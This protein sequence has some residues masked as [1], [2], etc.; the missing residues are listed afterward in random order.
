MDSKKPKDSGGGSVFG[1]IVKQTYDQIIVP[2]TKEIVNNAATD[3]IYMIG[4]YLSNVIGKRIFGPDS[5]VN[6]SKRSNNQTNYNQRYRTG[7]QRSSISTTQSVP[8]QQDIGMR[9]AADLQYVVAQSREQADRWKDEMINA[10]RKYGK[11]AVSDLY[12][13]TAENPDNTIKSV[14]TDF[15]Y[16]WTREDEIHWVH[17]RDGYYFDLPRPHKIR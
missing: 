5:T 8:Q 16:G 4:D 13:K 6:T 10:I 14:F 15:D 3:A 1:D 11:V 12:D 9:S 2:K 7:G 17:N